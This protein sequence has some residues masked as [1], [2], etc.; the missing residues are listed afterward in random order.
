MINVVNSLRCK[1]GASFTTGTIKKAQKL[2]IYFTPSHDAQD[3]VNVKVNC[4][5]L[6]VVATNEVDCEIA[7]PSGGYLPRT[8]WRWRFFC[9]LHS[10]YD[11]LKCFSFCCCDGYIWL[12]ST[13]EVDR[14]S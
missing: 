4:H 9:E 12:N 2:E 8:S 10:F 7:P 11:D 13:G 1:D 14:I 3:D 5:M 6:T